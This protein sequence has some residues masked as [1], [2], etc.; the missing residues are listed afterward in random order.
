MATTTPNQF[1]L[2]IINPY[3]PIMYLGMDVF[4]PLPEVEPDIPPPE[5]TKADFIKEFGHEFYELISDAEIDEPHKTLDPMFGAFLKIGK[6]MV[7]FD[8][9]G[10]DEELW[11]YLVSMFTGHHLQMAISRLKNQADEISLTPEKSDDKKIN[12]KIN[13]IEQESGYES[14]MYG[15]A[16]WHTYKPFLKFVHW[17]VYKAEGAI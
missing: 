9:L 8:I 5:F 1:Y 4:Y 3:D 7:D 6:S 15:Y 14:T 13:K 16:F 10:H 11:K 2:R 17:G 12:Y